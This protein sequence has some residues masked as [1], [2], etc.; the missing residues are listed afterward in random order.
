MLT[1]IQQ[2]LRLV[3]LMGNR[4]DLGGL[5]ASSGGLLILLWSE[6][7]NCAPTLNCT[8]AAAGP[9]CAHI[10]TKALQHVLSDVQES[11]LPCMRSSSEPDPEELSS[12]ADLYGSL[13]L[14][15]SFQMKDGRH[16]GSEWRAH[17]ETFLRSFSLANAGVEIHLR[18]KF[19]ELTSQPD[20]RVKIRKRVSLLDQSSLIL[21]VT[22]RTEP[23]LCIRTGC[24]CQGGH[25]VLGGSLPLSIPPQAMDQGLFGDLS[26]QLVTLL[27][28]CLDQYPNLTSKLTHIQLLVF[29]PSNVPVPGP[30][31]F[32]QTLPAALDC[33][34]L[35]LERLYCS[36]FKEL[37]HGGVT[38]YTV[39]TQKQDDLGQESSLSP[40][41][42]SLVLFLFT[43]HSDPFTSQITDALA[44]EVLI[45]RHLDDILSNN[46]KAVTAALQTQLRNTLKAQNDKKA[47]QK[48]L[49][50]AADVIVSSTI[51]IISCSTNLD[52]R[53]TCLDH[54]KVCNT[55][56]LSA[57]LR[58]SLLRVTSWKFVPRSRCH[59]E[60][61]NKHTQS[62]EQTRAEM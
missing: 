51:S 29:S 22:C 3:K 17:I 33:Q 45:E 48:K 6:S 24:W 36:S 4:R 55:G 2:V 53:T 39:E 46:R 47:N 21:D 32:F 18:F 42:Q 52:F 13:R 62:D 54:M 10:Q 12:F 5:K 23:P 25:P 60:Q 57:S 30:S 35:G 11:L 58:E 34:E 56:D 20:M 26:V 31:V 61:M 59:T 19:P 14:L 28:P 37:Q 7:S 41:P 27:N 50:S 16:Y 43:Q 44:S 1:E 38:V 49:L 8:V 15:L 40:V 9:W